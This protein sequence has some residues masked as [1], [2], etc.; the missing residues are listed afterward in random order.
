MSFSDHWAS[1]SMRSADGAG[2]G[3]GT[4]DQPSTN[5]RPFDL[6][7]SAESKSLDGTQPIPD[8]LKSL[9][10]SIASFAIPPNKS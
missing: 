2:A 10:D 8:Q 1:R 7:K 4:T 3:P 9:A 5:Q 6:A